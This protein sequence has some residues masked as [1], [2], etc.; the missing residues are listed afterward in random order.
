MTVIALVLMQ[1]S[2]NPLVFLTGCLFFLLFQISISK[3]WQ[4]QIAVIVLYIVYIG[5]TLCCLLCDRLYPSPLSLLCFLDSGKCFQCRYYTYCNHN[6]LMVYLPSQI[7]TF[8]CTCNHGN[9]MAT[10]YE[11]YM[12]SSLLKLLQCPM[13]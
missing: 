13:M 4:I 9:T 8:L 1:I 6:L 5:N 10:G 11:Y 2:I 7:T 12:H 3:S